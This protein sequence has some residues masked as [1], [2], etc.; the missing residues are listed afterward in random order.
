MQTLR[1]GSAFG[2]RALA[3]AAICAIT[4]PLGGCAMPQLEAQVD[5]AARAG[6]CES[7][8]QSATSSSDTYRSGGP[9]IIRYLAARAAAESWTSVAVSCPTRLTEGIV[10]AAQASYASERLAGRLGLEAGAP[11]TVDFSEV[12]QINMDA[13]ALSSIVLAEDRAGFCM[14]VLA[15][16]ETPNA[17][18]S[19]ADN[20]K[21]V[22]QRLFSL[23]GADSDPRQKVYAVDQLL[24]HPD[25]ID[26]PATGLTAP[27]AA[28]VEMNCARSWL[29]ALAQTET[30]SRPSKEWMASAA[31][32]RLW[33]AFDF[34]YPS[35]DA[36]LLRLQ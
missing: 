19:I 26:D 6:T 32:S 1:D 31:V 24:A 4:L 10:H 25:A 35:L 23:S 15:A 18:L 9:L 21:T 30:L 20:H 12:A 33:R 2:A 3:A 7:S 14:E 17:T 13:S 11:E 28:A 29:D 27:I 22:A 34:G 16:R 36:A 8:Y 5:E